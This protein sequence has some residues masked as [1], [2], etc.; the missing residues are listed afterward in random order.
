MSRTTRQLGRFFFLQV[1]KDQ[2]AV[3]DN[4]DDNEAN[5][6]GVQQVSVSISH[7]EIEEGTG[8]EC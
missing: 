4:D 5:D 8:A 3:D 6:E 2:A 7:F 1:G